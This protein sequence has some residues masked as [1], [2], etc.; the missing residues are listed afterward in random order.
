MWKSK[1]KMKLLGIEDEDEAWETVPDDNVVGELNYSKSH[2]QPSRE[3]KGQ[4]DK[5]FDVD[6]P[7]K[8]KKDK[9]TIE[10]KSVVKKIYRTYYYSLS[11]TLKFDYNKDS[12]FIGYSRPYKYTQLITDI[13]K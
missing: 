10:T 4:F 8:E 11:F 2:L 5:L 13:L 3:R 7:K 1:K 9:D 6:E 12:V